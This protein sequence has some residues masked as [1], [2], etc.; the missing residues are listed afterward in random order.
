MNI[1]IRTGLWARRYIEKEIT[2][3]QIIEKTVAADVLAELTIPPDEIGVV[4]INGK[5][6]PRD[7]ALKNGDTLEVLPIIIGG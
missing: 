4:L 5:A 6:V 7:T 1:T 3:M 2:E